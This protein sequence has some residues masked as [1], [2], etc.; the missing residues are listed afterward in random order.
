MTFVSQNFNLNPD[1]SVD[2][3]WEPSNQV[4]RVQTPATGNASLPST[5]TL[6]LSCLDTTHSAT[7]TITATF[8]PLTARHEGT[9]TFNGTSTGN[10]I[11]YGWNPA[12]SMPA[13]RSWAG[14]ATI[15]NVLYVVGGVTSAPLN[16]VTAF[17]PS[18]AAPWTTKA[19]MPTARAGA[20]VAVPAGTTRLFAIG[21]NIVGGGLSGVVETYD[22]STNQWSTQFAP[23]VPLAPMPTLRAGAGAAEV[24]GKIYVVGGTGSSGALASVD[25]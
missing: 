15:D 25:V 22:A 23:S 19:A 10:V 21:G 1:G 12:P 20:A 3:V 13:P 11:I 7:G 5:V 6:N 18:S 2:T 8:N 4:L 14:A 24:N 9:F 17:D 16:T